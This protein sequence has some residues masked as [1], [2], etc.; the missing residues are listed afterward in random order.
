MSTPANNIGYVHAQPDSTTSW[1][2]CGI[3]FVINALPV[4]ILRTYGLLY[5]IFIEMYGV[6]R[7]QASWPLSLVNS[8]LY[9]AGRSQLYA[10]YE[11][12]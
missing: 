1:L 5:V 7:S 8:M 4:G 3:A 2:I 12:F 10:M 11:V 6:P 9:L